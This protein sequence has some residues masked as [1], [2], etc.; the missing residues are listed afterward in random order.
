MDEVKFEMKQT[1][2]LWKTVDK[3]S[4]NVFKEGYD[5]GVSQIY[6]EADEAHKVACFRLLD[7]IND[8][9][10]ENGIANNV[11]GLK[12]HT[13]HIDR[14]PVSPKSP[15]GHAMVAS[16]FVL[17]GSC[18]V[19]GMPISSQIFNT[20][21][22]KDAKYR[23]VAERFFDEFSDHRS[24][25]YHRRAKDA[26]AE[27]EKLIAD[28]F[29]MIDVP[30]DVIGEL[31]TPLHP[32]IIKGGPVEANIATGSID[33]GYWICSQ[34]KDISVKSILDNYASLLG[35]AEDEFG[36]QRRL[37]NQQREIFGVD[38]EWYSLL[39]ED[40]KTIFMIKTLLM[41]DPERLKLLFVKR[42]LNTL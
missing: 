24:L 18:V 22:V 10:A 23:P 35:E 37:L 41:M 25:I 19:C 6:K 33:Y 21:S 36:L 3:A 26:K 13:M 14:H 38:V 9:S 11:T 4:P 30:D 15:E 42:K 28:G 39:H 27:V 5:S 20:A 40:D 29:V 17:I 8:V 12:L 16:Y 32:E 31:N 2:K 34:S 1:P 7:E